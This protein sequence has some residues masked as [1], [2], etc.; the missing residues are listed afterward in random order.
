MPLDYLVRHCVMIFPLGRVSSRMMSSAHGEALQGLWPPSHRARR[1]HCQHHALHSRRL[2]LSCAVA[3]AYLGWPGLELSAAQC[4]GMAW[5]CHCGSSEAL[6]QAHS[7]SCLTSQSPS[8]RS[9]TTCSL[10]RQTMLERS[11]TI[12]GD[13]QTP[14]TL[15][16]PVDGP[17]STCSPPADALVC[18]GL[19]DGPSSP[20]PSPTMPSAA[21]EVK[22]QRPLMYAS[23]DSQDA[24]AL[25]ARP[26]FSRLAL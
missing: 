21:T 25:Q 24:G 20:V 26:G 18:A 5:L 15:L 9:A 17:T 6:I 22:Q 7:G 19:S 12:R 11:R 2:L 8:S 16:R 10:D 14:Q 23:S 13:G 3:A 1:S 4:V